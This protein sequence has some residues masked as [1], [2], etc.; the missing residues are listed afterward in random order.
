MPIVRSVVFAIQQGTGSIY[1]ALMK[2]K[3]LV[4][5]YPA[6][7]KGLLLTGSVGVGK[8]HLAVRFSKD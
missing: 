3:M 4:N 8:T 7:E 2:A 1:W 5:E 6:V